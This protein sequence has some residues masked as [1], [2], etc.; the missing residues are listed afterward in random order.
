[1]TLGILLIIAVLLQRSS[2][3]IEGAIG[4]GSSTATVKRKRRGFEKFIFE[5]TIALIIL[6]VLS[7]MLPL[8]IG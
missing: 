8:A 5:A 1:M 7:I 3:G 6:F 4:G 2:Q